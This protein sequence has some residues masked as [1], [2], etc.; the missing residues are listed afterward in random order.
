MRIA[1]ITRFKH[2]AIWE[3]LL[4]LHWSQSELARRCGVCINTIG[5]IINLQ[6]KPNQI[7]ADKIQQVFGES[8]QYI[9]VISEWPETFCLRKG[10]NIQQ[11]KDVDIVSLEDSNEV[12]NIADK[13]DFDIK[14]RNE[15][16]NMAVE[17][18]QPKM[19]RSVESYFYNTEPAKKVAE[20]LGLGRERVRQ[21]ALMGL[22]RLRRDRQ[23]ME[24]II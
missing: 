14:E 5:N 15:Q 23:L 9:D 3:L 16:I 20:S 6:Y 11:I 19:R 18:L 7:L 10:F 2:G 13:F 1:A 24:S 22:H 12:M 17:R 21:L 8:G 4:R